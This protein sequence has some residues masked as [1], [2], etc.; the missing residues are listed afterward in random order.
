MTS[1]SEAVERAAEI[2]LIGSWIV[3]RGAIST[4]LGD[5]RS[6]CGR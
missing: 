6:S 4:D 1:R 5:A 3:A 2:G